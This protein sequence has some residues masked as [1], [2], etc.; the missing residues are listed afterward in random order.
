MPEISHFFGIVI[1]MYHDDHGPPHFHARSGEH[2]LRVRLTPVAILDG[3]FPP[4]LLAL[5]L[6][7]STLHEAALLANWH[8]VEAGERPLRIPPLE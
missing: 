4:R 1:T 7:W 5:V 3:H 6:E 2:R 8:R